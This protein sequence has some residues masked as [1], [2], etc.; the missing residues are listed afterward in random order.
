VKAVFIDIGTD[1]RDVG[2][3]MP[4]RIGV[5]SLERSTTASAERRLDLEGLSELLGRDQRSGVASVTGLAA[6]LPARRREGRSPPDLHC[7]W[8]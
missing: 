1:G 7:G 2:D 4:H 8:I 6:P 5:L 3:L